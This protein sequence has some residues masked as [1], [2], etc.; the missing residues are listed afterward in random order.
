M[1][2]IAR[3]ETRRSGATMT[4]TGKDADSGEPVLVT[5]VEKINASVTGG[6]PTATT[7]RGEVFEL[8]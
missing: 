6:K 5:G 8:A 7:V 2:T 3:W 1:Q 4:I